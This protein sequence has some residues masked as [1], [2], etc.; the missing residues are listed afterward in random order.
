MDHITLQGLPAQTAK[1]NSTSTGFQEP[2][3]LLCVMETNGGCIVLTVVNYQ[4]LKLHP[5]ESANHYQP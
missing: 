1:N 2:P 5:P 3:S 4:P